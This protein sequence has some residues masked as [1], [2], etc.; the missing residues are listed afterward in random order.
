M[1]GYHNISY[2][3]FKET[4]ALNLLQQMAANG[5]TPYKLSKICDIPRNSIARYLKGEIM[6]SVPNLV[7]LAYVLKCD[8]KDLIPSNYYV[9]L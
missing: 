5:Y 7:N 4:F 9:E 1:Y 6:P 3:D 2:E 8:V